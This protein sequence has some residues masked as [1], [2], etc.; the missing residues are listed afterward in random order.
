M[1]VMCSNN[2]KAILFD[3]GKVLNESRT[4]HW[5]MPTKFFEYVDKKI[6]ESV[7]KKKISTAF[8]KLKNT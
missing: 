3:S 1:Q 8:K 5:F 6:F 4:G 7:N 2:I